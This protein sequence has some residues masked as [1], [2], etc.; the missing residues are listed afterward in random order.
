MET[1]LTTLNELEVKVA[2][3][4]EPDLNWSLSSIAF[5]V[6][7]RIFNKKKYPDCFDYQNNY[8]EWLQLVGGEENV[9]IRKFLSKFR[10]A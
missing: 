3:F 9:K 6:D 5:I 4:Q 2:T 1:H 10:L 7:E 8:E